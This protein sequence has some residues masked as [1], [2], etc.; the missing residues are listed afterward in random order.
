MKILGII[1]ARYQSTRF[2][3]KP[4]V[5][6]LGKPMIQRV[7]EQCKKS[8]LL[9]EI[10]VATDD[11]RIASVVKDFGGKVMLTKESHPSGTDRCLEVLENYKEPVDVVI[12]IQG[13]EPFIDPNQIDSLAKLFG[14]PKTQIA[15]LI[16]KISH[17]EELF[18]SNVVKAVINKHSEA[19]YFSR[20]AI[21]FIRG[22]ETEEWLNNFTF[23]KHIGI[24]GF[25][26]DVLRS[27]GLLQAS[28]LELAESLE[29]N[30]WLENGF[31]IKTAYTDLESVA[32]DSPADLLKISK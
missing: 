24:Y 3:G 19:L 23:N 11:E 8:T 18:N 14:D 9:S 21:P 31:S 29:Q 13:D 17:Q 25:K 1:P 30:R 22:K 27:I 26:A 16:K 4:L 7:Y 6:I 5:D 15:T 10:I 20:Q 2:P 28:S 32:I 12:N